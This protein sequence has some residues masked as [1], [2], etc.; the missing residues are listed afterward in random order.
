MSGRVLQ[1]VG[2]RASMCGVPRGRV[3]RALSALAG[4][5]ALRSAAT[6]ALG[7]GLR[8]RGRGVTASRPGISIPELEKQRSPESW[9]RGRRFAQT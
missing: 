1:V 5:A 3:P 9:C 2:P 4:G 8:H 7:F 6:R